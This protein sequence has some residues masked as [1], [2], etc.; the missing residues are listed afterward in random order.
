MSFRL[1]TVLCLNLAFIGCGKKPTEETTAPAN[2]PKTSVSIESSDGPPPPPPPTAAQTPGEP[3]PDTVKPGTPE[4][5][6]QAEATPESA[7]KQFAEGERAEKAYQ[8][9]LKR[10]AVWLEALKKADPSTQQ[11]ILGEI[12]A[13][14]LSPAEI[15]ELEAIKQYFGVTVSFR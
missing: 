13:A 14:R 10:N 1:A 15:Q 11:R 2:A 7:M 6:P 8:E 4:A 5:L 3:A 9:R 12:R